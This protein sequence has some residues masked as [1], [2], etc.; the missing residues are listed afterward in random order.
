[1][2]VICHVTQSDS[3]G[4]PG[5][6][7]LAKR[8]PF[9]FNNE[10]RRAIE[11]RHNIEEAPPGI[12]STS[13]DGVSVDDSL[14]HPS[15]ALGKPRSCATFCNSPDLGVLWTDF[16]DLDSFENTPNK[17]PHYQRMYQKA[18]RN[19]TRIWKIVRGHDANAVSRSVLTCRP[20]TPGATC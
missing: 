9:S 5:A 1:M 7:P 19:H 4:P 15:P 18:Y 20:S 14:L 2:H 6:S 11:R 17:V 3:T 13:Q 12:L 16:T 10:P 8:V